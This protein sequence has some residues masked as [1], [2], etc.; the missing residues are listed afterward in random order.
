MD[1]I[2]SCVYLEIH[3]SILGYPK[4]D[5]V[6]SKNRIM[7]IQKSVLI[8]HVHVRPGIHRTRDEVFANM[9]IVH[10]NWALR[11]VQ[12]ILMTLLFCFQM[13]NVYLLGLLNMLKTAKNVYFI[14]LRLHSSTQTRKPSS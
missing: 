6:I 3:N 9:K 13:S 7:D 8:R 4:I 10:V 12:N 2:K 1:I 14:Y 5:L 11:L